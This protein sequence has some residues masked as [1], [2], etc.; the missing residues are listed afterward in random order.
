M[1]GA[2]TVTGSQHIVEANGHR[3]LRDCGLYQ[4]KRKLAKKINSELPFDAGTIDSMVLSHAHIDHCGNIPSLTK[5]GYEGPIHTTTATA[6]LCE[7]ML[8]DAA[9]IQE[10]DAAYLNQKTSRKGYPP[11]E[12][13][14]T[15]EDA[16]AALT[17]FKGHHYHDT[18][19]VMPGIETHSVEAGHILGAELTVMTV[20]ENGTTRRIGFAVDLGRHNLPLIRDPEPM[21]EVDVLVME[22]TYG[23]RYHD[24]IAE[25]D[26]RL[27]D[28][29]KRTYQRGGKVIIPSFALERAQ[30]I[31][32]HLATLRNEGNLPNVPVYVDSP[33]ATAVTQ[34]FSKKKDYLD[35]EFHELRESMGRIL[36][37]DWIHFVSSVKE[38]K[39]LTASRK[40]VIVI[41]ASGMCEHGRILHHL[42]DAIGDE[43]NSI[44]I[45]GYQAEHTLG[46]RLVE[47]QKEVR[48][49]GDT[50]ER[51]A[52][53]EVLNAFSAHADRN[54]LLAYARQ[55]KAAR[56]FLVHGEQESREAL[57]AALAE[58][59]LGEVHLPKRGDVFEL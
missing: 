17:L 15:T 11:V 45:V 22:S 1:G 44:A 51:K 32:F 13:L 55:V 9:K 19:E 12:P 3:V 53:V 35:K 25:A 20:R 38:S 57:A 24:N 28:V 21:G 52:E 50:F 41:A 34:V 2:D 58:E 37:S 59:G 30:E 6:A 29:I 23:N 7:I 26:S 14:Y 47:Q 43:R 5:A 40:P 4:G 8:R 27:G 33:M 42:K 39:E 18:F 48:I 56:T 54:D 31:L 46:R 16:E 49:F 36:S 10:Q